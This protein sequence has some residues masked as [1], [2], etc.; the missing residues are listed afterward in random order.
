MLHYQYKDFIHYLQGSVFGNVIFII[1]FLGRNEYFLP[2]GINDGAL[3]H[4]F[5]PSLPILW[6]EIVVLTEEKSWLKKIDI[7]AGKSE[8]LR[9]TMKLKCYLGDNS[10]CPTL[11]QG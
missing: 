10:E 11:S 5:I 7:L 2:K 3:A 4:H 6:D 9:R 1:S 8:F